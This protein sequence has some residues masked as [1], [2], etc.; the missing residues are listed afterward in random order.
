MGDAADDL[1]MWFERQERIARSRPIVAS[2][3]GSGW[4]KKFKGTERGGAYI[5]T[6]PNAIDGRAIVENHHGISFNGVRY[7]SIEQAK[8]AALSPTAAP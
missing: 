8:L 7:P 2:Q 4:R 3:Q 5:H 1:D 6:H